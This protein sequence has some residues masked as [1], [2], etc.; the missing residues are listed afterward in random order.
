MNN[1][2][3]H[4]VGTPLLHPWEKKKKKNTREN[5][6]VER[7]TQTTLHSVTENGTHIGVTFFLCA[8][9]GFEQDTVVSVCF[10]WNKLQSFWSI[11]SIRHETSMRFMSS[12]EL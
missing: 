12:Q 5:V 11:M 6:C 9:F 8:H 7:K 4:A 1:Y 10:H 2:E 3:K